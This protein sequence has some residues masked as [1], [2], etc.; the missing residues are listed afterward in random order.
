MGRRNPLA[1]GILTGLSLGFCRLTALLPLPAARALGRGLARLAYF[2]VPRMRSIGM[3]NLDLAYGETLTRAEKESILRESARNL[4][5]VAAEFSRIP[6]IAAGNMGQWFRIRGLENID[7]TRGSVFMGAH[8]GNWEWLAP[9]AATAGINS[10]IIV[11]G[12]DDPRMDNAVD[13]IR[14]SGRVQTLDKNSATGP[15]L[16][17][18]REGWVAGILADQNPRENGIPARFFGVTT[19]ATVGPVLIARRARA[20][21]YPVS[22]ARDEAG[23]YTLEFRPAL[24]LQ[25]TG[26]LL[27]DLAVNTQ[28]C[29]DAIEAM[30]REHPGQWLWF[31][32]RWR[33]RERLEQEWEARQSRHSDKG[34]ADGDNGGGSMEKAPCS[35]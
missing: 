25:A 24:E 32:R 16:Q 7:R 35:E 33:R 3:A 12:F 26:D 2:A 9:A 10:V 6:R 29:Q 30:V 31:H 23:V 27:A 1:Q 11:R 8:L 15:M 18:M 22:M 28:R 14:Q 4:G 21:I 13:A 34:G 17:R 20:P 19:W 5:L